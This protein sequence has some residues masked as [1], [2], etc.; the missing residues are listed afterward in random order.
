MSW[1]AYILQNYFPSLPNFSLLLNEHARFQM[2]RIWMLDPAGTPDTST[3]CLEGSVL[4]GPFINEAEM[5]RKII[6]STWCSCWGLTPNPSHSGTC[7]VARSFSCQGIFS[8]LL[9]ATILL[10][11]WAMQQSLYPN[12]PPSPG[13]L[14]PLLKKPRNTSINVS[15]F[16]LVTAPLTIW[17]LKSPWEAIIC[18]RVI[19]RRGLFQPESTMSLC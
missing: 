6:F 17:D 8:S 12:L 10:T 5:V 19:K 7:H 16:P 3:F 4:Y 18:T 9:E 13:Q 15:S 1:L 14:P 2:R 11:Q